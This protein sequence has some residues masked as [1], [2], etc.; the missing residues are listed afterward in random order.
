MGRLTFGIQLTPDR[1]WPASPVFRVVKFIIDKQIIFNL[2]APDSSCLVGGI[3]RRLLL[4]R[5]TRHLHLRRADYESRPIR[6]SDC[7][8]THERYV[9]LDR[10]GPSSRRHAP[11]GRFH[12][13]VVKEKVN[14]TMIS[15]QRHKFRD[16][17]IYDYVKAK[18]NHANQENEKNKK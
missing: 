7:S 14:N 16:Q 8:L 12:D 5:Q 13:R 3:Y 4:R 10:A 17:T 2:P 1:I 15:M 6:V 9:Y 11:A 18:R